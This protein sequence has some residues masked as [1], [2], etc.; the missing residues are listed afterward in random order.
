MK[1]SFLR[2][3]NTPLWYNVLLIFIFNEAAVVPFERDQ[4]NTTQSIQSIIF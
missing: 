1:R 3:I 2:S 4:F